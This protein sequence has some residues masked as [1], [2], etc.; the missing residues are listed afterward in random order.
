MS[1]V[2]EHSALLVP[3]KMLARPATISGI[4]AVPDT[5]SQFLV[6][7]W[8]IVVPDILAT[9]EIS[10]VGI[11]VRNSIV[12]SKEAFCAMPLAASS[13][14]SALAANGQP[15]WKQWCD[16][17]H[18]VC[19]KYAPSSEVFIPPLTFTRAEESASAHQASLT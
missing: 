8:P 5:S 10:G 16:C 14:L 2:F 3:S 13:L 15:G 12:A 19:R 11:E 17:S 4:L 18:K 6:G 1:Y 7:L 9:A